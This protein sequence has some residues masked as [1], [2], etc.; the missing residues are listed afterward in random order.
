MYLAGKRC[1]TLVLKKAVKSIQSFLL[2]Y[3]AA[4]AFLLPYHADSCIAYT[5]LSLLATTGSGI[6][7]IQLNQRKTRK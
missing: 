3:Y 4:V 6:M 2:P 7:Y 1:R 5:P